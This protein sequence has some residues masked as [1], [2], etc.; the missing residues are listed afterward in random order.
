[1]RSAGF[2]FTFLGVLLIAL[3]LVV[4]P[5]AVITLVGLVSAGIGLG[6]R[7]LIA[8]LISGVLLIFEDQFA[9]GEKVEIDGVMGTVEFVNIRTTFIRS[10]TGEL[11]IVP[12]GDVRVVRNFSRGTFSPANIS[13]AVPARQLGPSILALRRVASRA[14][15]E[16]DEVIEEP[17]LFSEAGVLASEVMLT[18]KVKARYGMGAAVRTR[19]L[20]MADQELVRIEEP[21]VTLPAS[22]PIMA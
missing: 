1:V 8:D 5:V 6:A 12:N 22:A 13:V 16:L 21:V 15:A 2:A 11:Y 19:L 7:P 18:L 17:L 3:A 4:G 20:E 14:F 9:V 10:D